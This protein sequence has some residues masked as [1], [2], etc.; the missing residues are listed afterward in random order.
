MRIPNKYLALS[1]VLVSAF[2]L[3]A[4]PDTFDAGKTTANVFES[5][6]FHFRYEFPKGWFALDDS[7]RMAENKKRYETDLKE[8]L[9]QN[10]PDSATSHTE[11]V[12]PYFLLVAGQSAVTASETT[13]KPRVVIMATKRRNMMS[14]PRDPARTIIEMIHPKVLKGPEDLVLAGRQFSRT[15]L[16][17]NP[18]SLLS[19]FATVV[20]EYIIEF[21]LRADNEKDLA[22]LVNTMQSL[23]FTDH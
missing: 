21:D 4:T 7:V 23:Q 20:G 6:F 5:P 10:G 19:K 3:A 1:F 15:D 22:N 14:G 8:A 18:K 13:Q 9:D 16:E 12:D 17:F 11:V 2:A